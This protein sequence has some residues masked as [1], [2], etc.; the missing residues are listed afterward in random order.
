MIR[1]DKVTA[2]GFLD[3]FQE[4]LG[5]REYVT[6][7]YLVEYD[8][9][10]VDHR[11]N[12]INIKIEDV[13]ATPVRALKWDYLIGDEPIDSREFIIANASYAE[14]FLHLSKPSGQFIKLVLYRFFKSQRVPSKLLKTEDLMYNMQKKL[15]LNKDLISGKIEVVENNIEDDKLLNNLLAEVERSS[16]Q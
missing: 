1:D 15:H 14:Y 7:L 13:L 12:Q 6:H 9:S 5:K 16:N 11:S 2:Q 8:K 10:I 4:L 3:I